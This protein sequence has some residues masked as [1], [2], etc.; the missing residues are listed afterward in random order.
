[1]PA[2]TPPICHLG[3]T[4]LQQFGKQHSFAKGFCPS[5]VEPGTIWCFEQEHALLGLN[6]A[7]TIRMT[8]VKLQNG[9]LLVYA[10]VAPTRYHLPIACWPQPKGHLGCL[11]TICDGL[12]LSLSSAPELG[13]NCI[14]GIVACSWHFRHSALLLIFYTA[15]LP[16]CQ[17]LYYCKQSIF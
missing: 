6:V 16:F 3:I 17:E 8:V 7:T 2:P 11:T 13:I 12:V 4:A 10:P 5:Q 9:E 1:M 15:C 14:F